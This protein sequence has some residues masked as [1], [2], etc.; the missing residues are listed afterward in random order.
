MP[1]PLTI[2][3]ISDTHI[4]DRCPSLNPAILR[5]FRAEGV[6]SILHG[7]DVCIPAVL[8]ELRLIAPVYAVRGNRD[9]FFLREL[10][11]KHLLEFNGVR[12]GLSHGHGSF[13]EYLGDKVRK[14]AIGLEADHIQRRSA[15]AFQDVHVNVFGHIHR[16]FREW[17]NGTLFFAPGSACCS[18]VR[19]LPPSAGLL[20]ITTGGDVEAEIFF[21]D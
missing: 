2:G 14:M 7:G 20:R 10:P 5:R 4:P 11:Q 21:L 19:G 15:A 13:A 16:P 12:L 17:I 6:A 9:I 3:V 8:E 1:V 18:E